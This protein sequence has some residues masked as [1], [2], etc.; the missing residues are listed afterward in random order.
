MCSIVK[1]TTLRTVGLGLYLK[2]SS[3]PIYLIL[4]F[5][6]PD[7]DPGGRMDY[8]Y[9]S[10]HVEDINIFTSTEILVVQLIAMFM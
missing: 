8:C 2:V 1:W 7:V 3:S 4:A 9:A 10:L 6:I 5:V